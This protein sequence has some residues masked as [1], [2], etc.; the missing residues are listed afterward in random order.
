MKALLVSIIIL[1][2][3]CPL[4]KNKPLPVAET[5]P[6][7]EPAL[8]AAVDTVPPKPLAAPVPGYINTGSATP[9][10]VLAY[11]KTLQ[12]IPY[13]YASTDP[14]QGF[15]CSGFITFVF[16]HFRI[17]VPRSSVDFTHINREVSLAA[18]KPGDLILFTGTDSTIRVVGHMGILTSTANGDY[19]FIHSSSGKSY[20]VTISPLSNYYLGRFVKVIR[21]FPGND[22]SLL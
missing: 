22:N 5:A 15:D 2:A 19:Q 18:A 4:I 3:S 17:A 10:E 9:G 14:A 13:K 21:I 7:P 6:V 12:G 1:F 8:A 16:N 11:A 20:G